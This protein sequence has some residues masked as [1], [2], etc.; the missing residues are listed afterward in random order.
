VNPRAFKRQP[1]CVTRVNS[2]GK[3]LR[4]TG[5]HLYITY[6]RLVLSICA[7]DPGLCS[8]HLILARARKTGILTMTTKTQKDPSNEELDRLL[9][10][11]Q[12]TPGWNFREWPP[13]RARLGKCELIV[14]VP[15]LWRGLRCSPRPTA[16]FELIPLRRAG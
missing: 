12:K 2:R 8:E 6:T 9:A 5:E 4:H 1:D 15:I 11:A 7:C 13:I 14:I 3:F 10:T 16:P